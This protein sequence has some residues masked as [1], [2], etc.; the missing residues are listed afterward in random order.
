MRLVQYSSRFLLSLFC[1]CFFLC[2]KMTQIGL[3][4]PSYGSKKFYARTNAYLL[5]FSFFFSLI[6]LLLLLYFCEQ[7]FLFEL[8]KLVFALLF[9]YF[10]CVVLSLVVFFFFCFFI[11]F[12]F[13][14]YR[15][16]SFSGIGSS[17]DTNDTR[18]FS[19]SLFWS[20]LHDKTRRVM[21]EVYFFI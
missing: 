2:L 4:M 6:F 3:T 8:L 14:S 12:Y 19:S 5:C 20:L 18:S 9:I 15:F 13:N 16:I 1:E 17:H 21:E 11:L 7:L 10:F